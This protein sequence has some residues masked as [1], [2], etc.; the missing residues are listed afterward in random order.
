MS[1]TFT[2]RG[3][4]SKI[5]EKDWPC[6]ER[7]VS[8]AVDELIPLFLRGDLFDL[9]ADLTLCH[10]RYRLNLEQL[11]TAGQD[12]FFQEII[13][14]NRT[15]DRKTGKLPEGVMPRY[16]IKAVDAGINAKRA[17]WTRQ[18]QPALKECTHE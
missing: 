14:I 3:R 8:R 13:R 6:I 17:H 15:I 9:M 10:R 16:R 1:I 2:I 12:E 4:N 5:A 18:P 7:I 11:A